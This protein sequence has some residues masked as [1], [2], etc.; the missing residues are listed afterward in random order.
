MPVAMAKQKDGKSNLASTLMGRC[1]SQ[2]SV[3]AASTAAV[4]SR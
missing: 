4:L 2:C 3:A 1:F